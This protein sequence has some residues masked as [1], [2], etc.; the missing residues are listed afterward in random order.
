ML[1]G[2]QSAES[3]LTA[4]LKDVPVALGAWT[5]LQDGVLD[6]ETLDVLRLTTS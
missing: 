5:R 4:C 6:Q 3:P 1:G 2:A